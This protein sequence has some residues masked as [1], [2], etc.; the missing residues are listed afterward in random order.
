M[1]YRISTEKSFDQTILSDFSYS[2]LQEIASGLAFELHCTPQTAAEIGRLE[3][4]I[5]VRLLWDLRGN[6][7][8][9]TYPQSQFIAWNKD[10]F[11]PLVIPKA[12]MEVEINFK[13]YDLY[14]R[15]LNVYEGHE[16]YV[17]AQKV[18]IDG[19]PATR[20]RFKKDYYFVIND[21]R[22]FPF[23]SRTFGPVPEDHIIGKK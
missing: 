21:N 14:K 6:S 10:Y 19:S 20:Y 13:N 4:V 22:D 2:D 5:T 7:K 1:K 12:G 18:Y 3:G 17:N 9:N 23:D 15:I 11:G 16:S 8:P